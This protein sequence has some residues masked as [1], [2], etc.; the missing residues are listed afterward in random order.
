MACRILFALAPG[1]ASSA[2]SWLSGILSD[3]ATLRSSAAMAGHRVSVPISTMCGCPPI[4]PLPMIKPV[5]AL[6]KV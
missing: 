4:L 1:S 3:T 6:L 2:A 5:I